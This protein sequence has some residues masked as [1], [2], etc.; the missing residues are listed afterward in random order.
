MSWETKGTDILMTAPHA[1]YFVSM[2][3]FLCCFQV[4]PIKVVGKYNSLCDK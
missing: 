2:R 4:V 1:Q 3:S